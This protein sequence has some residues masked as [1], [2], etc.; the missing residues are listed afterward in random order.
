MQDEKPL[1]G[2]VSDIEASDIEERVARAAR[3]AKKSFEF[4]VRVDV[5]TTLP[6][7]KKEVDFV[8]GHRLKQPVEVYGQI[9]HSTTS[10]RA[11]DQVREGLLNE[12]FRKTGWLPLKVLWWWELSTQDMANR[13]ITKI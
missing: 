10:Q 2:F 9:G 1:T 8:F 11:N 5:K 12:T 3:Q 13:A 6:N 7:M 4:Q